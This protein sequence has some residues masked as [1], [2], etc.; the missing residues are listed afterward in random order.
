MSR[1]SQYEPLGAQQ[2]ARAAMAAHR[3]GA[4][5]EGDRERP[6]PNSVEIARKLLRSPG[7]VDQKAEAF[8][9]RI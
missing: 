9:T 1:E 2:A 3:L 4:T 7:D 6:D 8:E 5:I